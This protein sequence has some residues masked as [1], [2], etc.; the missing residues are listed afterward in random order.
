LFFLVLGVGRAWFRGPHFCGLKHDVTSVFDPASSG[1]NMWATRH[2]FEHNNLDGMTL[3]LRP[4]TGRPCF[5][6]GRETIDHP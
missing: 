3:I 5:D 4:N 1:G 6:H 2:T